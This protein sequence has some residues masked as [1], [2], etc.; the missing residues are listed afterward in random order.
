MGKKV[1][2]PM[3]STNRLKTALVVTAVACAACDSEPGK[4]AAPSA[5][6]VTTASAPTTAL[7][8]LQAPVGDAGVS[9]LDKVAKPGA[10]VV[11]LAGIAHLPGPLPDRTDY[12]AALKWVTPVYSKPDRDS[13]RLGSL[14]TG[15]VVA[16]RSTP[17]NA[18]GCKG[19]W[20]AIEP[21]GFVCAGKDAT[22]D[23][24][25]PVVRATSRRPEYAHR[26]PYMYGTVTRGGPMYARLPTAKDLKKFE[27][28]LKKHMAKWRDDKVSGAGYGLDVWLRYTKKPAPPAWQ[29]WQDRVTDEDIPWFLRDGRQVPNV[30]GWVKSK[31]AVKVGQIDRRTG[32]SFIYSFLYEGRRYNVTPDLLVIPADRFRPIRGS[33]FNGW[34]IGRELEFPFALVRRPGAKKWQWDAAQ[35]KMVDGGKL[36]WRSAVT[37][38]GK[39]RFYQKKL[40]YQSKQG[41]WVDDRHAGRVD[42]ARHWPKWAKNG[43]KWLDINITKQVLVAY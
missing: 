29:A 20:H 26:L 9:A 18:R 15:A 12:I 25:H 23:L 10:P 31:D 22:T 36:R 5:T 8:D 32:R 16:I 13:R 39:Q 37:L 28:N 41:F 24:N 1:S 38:T 40:H 4:P 17:I 34:Q 6:T 27:P 2:G 3:A 11:D 21:A 7:D 35:K 19:G 30:S 14:R 42:P 33:K 43:E